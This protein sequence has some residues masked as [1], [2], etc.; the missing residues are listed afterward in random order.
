MRFSTLVKAV[1]ALFLRSELE[2]VA[3]KVEGEHC[4]FP[5]F[6][7]K[8]SAH[9]PHPTSSCGSVDSEMF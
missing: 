7:V 1:K 8:S 4:L 9:Q 3:N 2:G 5:L 6:G